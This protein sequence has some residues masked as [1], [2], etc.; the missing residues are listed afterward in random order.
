MA[1]LVAVTGLALSLH[2][3]DTVRSA[4]R[5]EAKLLLERKADALQAI[6][7]ERVAQYR[8]WAAKLAWMQAEA[9]RNTPDRVDTDTRSTPDAIE[10]DVASAE[11]RDRAVKI[12]RAVEGVWS[13]TSEL[14][15]QP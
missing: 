5:A 11:E 4:E 3:Y 12:A 10:G 8:Q 9:E 7:S 15:I 14:Q 13:V 1:T 6:I 2:V